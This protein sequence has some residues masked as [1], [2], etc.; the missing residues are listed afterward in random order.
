M[1]W[2]PEEVLDDMP[3]VL[4]A[5][6]AYKQADRDALEMR[7]RARAVLGLAVENELKK[8]GQTQERIAKNL[9]VVAEQIRRYRQAYRDWLRDHP[10]ESLTP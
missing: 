8:P 7:F 2:H 9:G 3:E 10:G 6:D 1:T 4:E 5:R